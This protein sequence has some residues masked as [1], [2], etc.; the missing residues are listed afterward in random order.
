M[1]DSLAGRLRLSK[2]KPG[3]RFTPEDCTSLLFTSRPPWAD[4]VSSGD[5]CTAVAQTEYPRQSWVRFSEWWHPRNVGTAVVV[6]AMM[7][8]EINDAAFIQ[9]GSEAFYKLDR[10]IR[11]SFN[12]LICLH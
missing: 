2:S 9:M 5:V 1:A 6:A 11:T 12:S 7:L 4:A 8:F 3:S 10:V